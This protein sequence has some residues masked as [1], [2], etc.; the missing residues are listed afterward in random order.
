MIRLLL[1]V[2]LLAA[3]CGRNCTL[4][5]R[6]SL[7]VFIEDADGEP[8]Q[9]EEVQFTETDLPELRPCTAGDDRSMWS[10]GQELGGAFLVR[11]EVDGRLYMA[12]ARVD[13]NDCGIITESVW[14]QTTP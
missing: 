5:I 2:L 10:C 11:A 3:G 4:D 1:I 7:L 8:V 6:P 14:I 13:S 12:D 9:A